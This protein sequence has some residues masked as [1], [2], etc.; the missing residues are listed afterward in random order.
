MAER[1]CSLG[2]GKP[3]HHRGW[4]NGHYKRW[5]R[6]GDPLGFPEPPPPPPFSHHGKAE[7]WRPVAGYEGLYD[8][9][10]LGRVRSLRRSSTSGRV[11]KPWVQAGYGYLAVKLSCNSVQAT[12]LVHKLVA[13]AFIGPCPEGQQV[14]HGPNGKLDNRAS[15]LC[16]G[17]P[18]DDGQ[19]RVRDGSSR[20]GVKSHMAKLTDA[21]VIE[22]RRRRATGELQR[23][24]A[25]SYD[26]TAS[27]VSMI[28]NGKIWRHLLPV[29]PALDGAL[30]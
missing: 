19:D 11:L 20:K 4:C 3:V 9:S 30:F 6:Y 28:V 2:D 7:E 21:D 12:K 29:T 14:R 25:A 18:K 5:W 24:I 13:E 26:I 16:Y 27:L 15:Q 17:T 10:S 1:T 22:I 23:T 8:V